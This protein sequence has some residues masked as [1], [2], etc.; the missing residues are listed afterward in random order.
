SKDPTFYLQNLPEAER[1]GSKR[2]E[3]WTTY[4]HAY[5]NNKGGITLQYWRF[6]PYNT[7]VLLGMRLD[8][9]SHGGDWEA[10][11]VVLVASPDF[12]PLELRLVGHRQ[13]TT[14]PWGLLTVDAGHPVIRAERGSHTSELAGRLDAANRDKFI[15]HYSWTD[16]VV[17]WPGG[18]RSPGSA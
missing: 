5:C 18:R 7:G 14:V 2:T 16:G 6:Y 11:H 17:R 10:V 1:R 3:D 4:C 13:I 12:R 8:A 9:T 15:T